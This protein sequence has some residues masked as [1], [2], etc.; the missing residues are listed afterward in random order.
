L[1]LRRSVAVRPDEMARRRRHAPVSQQGI[2]PP[3]VKP[4]ARFPAHSDS[5][6]RIA[7]VHT[8]RDLIGDDGEQQSNA[9]R[10]HRRSWRRRIVA[11][12][13]CSNLA[14]VQELLQVTARGGLEEAPH[15]QRPARGRQ[16]WQATARQLRAGQLQQL[17]PDHARVNRIDLARCIRGSHRV[18][19]EPCGIRNER[20][21]A[22]HCFPSAVRQKKVIGIAVGT[23]YS[24]RSKPILLHNFSPHW[25]R[26]SAAPAI[27]YPPLAQT[28]CDN[29]RRVTTNIQR[30]LCESAEHGSKRKQVKKP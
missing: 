21:G 3:P 7:V 2:K 16:R 6:H 9:S 10:A 15:I 13:A 19:H 28:P 26:F 5:H 23:L 20:V 30:R 12:Q 18:R 4:V 14:T 29:V 25:K 8:L 11:S 27:E 22:C 24:R 1:P 17:S